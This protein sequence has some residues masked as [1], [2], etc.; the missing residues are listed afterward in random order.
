MIPPPDSE[1]GYEEDQS[2]D[3]PA[4]PVSTI[5]LCA[6]V[7]LAG[8]LNIVKYKKLDI[9]TARKQAIQRLSRRRKTAEF[10]ADLPSPGMSQGLSR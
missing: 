4:T 10:P 7:V 3:K 1:S 9:K 5:P 2:I 8:V 6:T